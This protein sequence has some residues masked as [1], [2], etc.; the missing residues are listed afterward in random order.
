MLITSRIK[1]TLP[2][3]KETDLDVLPADKARELLLEISRRIGDHADELSKLCGYLPLALRNTGS[4]LAERKD[5]DVAEYERRLREKMARLEL[6]D[7][8]FS[9]SYE[10]LAP[11]RKKQ[12]CRLSVFPED[13]DRDGAAAVWKMGPDPSAETLSD[14]VKWSILEFNKPVGSEVGRYRLHDL[15]RLFAESRL[16]SSDRVDAHQCQARHY[17]KVL[18]NAEKLYNKGG[19]NILAGLELFDRE[20]MNIKIGQAWI[21]GLIRNAGKPKNGT[22]LK[23][24]LKLADNISGEGTYVLNLRLHPMDK[25]HW[26]GTS[27]S[28]AHRM[29]DR[30][31]EGYWLMNL[32]LAY[33]DLGE[34]RKAVEYYEQALAIARK[35]GDLAD[36]ESGTLNNMGNA[37]TDLGEAR[38]AIKCYERSLAIDRKTGD[39][40]GEGA[41][42]VFSFQNN[43]AIFN[44]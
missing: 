24:A 44:R 20:W 7:A 21:E 13:F 43:I 41:T 31:S 25:I 9:L 36:L 33:S 40:R 42:L 35:F 8:S 1:F 14:L 22:T 28:A 29:K 37:Y 4:A 34:T 23:L 12:W 3:L 15:A 39:I 10:L 16:D 32:G 19:K 38:E 17:M 27:L 5:L 30:G 11:I 18:S 2:G 6:V 26:F